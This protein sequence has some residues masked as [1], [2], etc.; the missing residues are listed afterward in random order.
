MTIAEELRAK[1]AVLNAW[2][3]GY[4]KGF[5]IHFGK[6]WKL[7]KG[8]FQGDSKELWRPSVNCLN[9][10]EKNIWCLWGALVTWNWLPGKHS[11][12]IGY[13]DLAPLFILQLTAIWGS[14]WTEGAMTPSKVSWDQ[15]CFFC[16]L[17]GNS[18]FLAQIMMAME[19]RNLVC[20]I[21]KS[22][23]LK[24]FLGLLR[25]RSLGAQEQPGSPSSVQRS[26]ALWLDSRA[27]G[28][29]AER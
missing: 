9:T 27:W 15:R 22:L 2:V 14:P 21:G 18:C 12:E 4:P 10:L 6:S 11:C 25:W 7:H 29:L 20:D 17:V 24:P 19:R 5:A 8:F 26:L 1:L 16:L 3:S 23:Y 13:V 28:L